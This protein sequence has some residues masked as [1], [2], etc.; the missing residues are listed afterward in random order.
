MKTQHTL[1]VTGCALLSALLLSACS[2][3]PQSFTVYPGTHE[4]PD[5]QEAK[6]YTYAG[7][8]AEAFNN[9]G[10]PERLLDRSSELVTMS[11]D[12]RGALS[13][14]AAM[15]RDDRPTRAELNCMR[16]EALCM[17]ARSIFA[18]QRI[19]TEFTGGGDDVVLVYERVIVRDCD[20]RF[21]DNSSNPYN[22]PMQQ[23]GCSVVG[24]TMQMVSDKSQFVDPALMD[25]PD[26]DKAVQTYRRYQNP[27]PEPT[28]NNQSVLSTISTQ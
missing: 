9:P 28:H 27:S 23:L 13:E 14:I 6:P 21:V 16:G 24:N 25:M 18:N 2:N 26:G 10:D 3:Q 17:E 4:Y 15:V 11:L 7:P 5:Q 1:Y 20:S 22:V 12:S 8:P 19:P